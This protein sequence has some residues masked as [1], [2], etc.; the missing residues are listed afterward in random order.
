MSYA[1]PEFCELAEATLLVAGS[2]GNASKGC[3]E[4]YLA[5]FKLMHRRDGELADTFNALKRPTA[6]LQLTSMPGQELL[7]DKEFM[8]FSQ[9]TRDRIHAFLELR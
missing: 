2:E 3:H 4:R 8:T 1:I 7:T 9:A 5:L 6:L